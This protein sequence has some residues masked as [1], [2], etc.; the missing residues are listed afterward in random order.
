MEM[1]AAD[2]G[3][4]DNTGR[5]PEWVMWAAIFGIGIPSAWAF[6]LF[7]D[8]LYHCGFN[9]GDGCDAMVTYP[10]TVGAVF[11]AALFGAFMVICIGCVILLTWG[12]GKLCYDCRPWSFV[13]GNDEENVSLTSEV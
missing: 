4:Y 13:S 6:G 1:D 2:G 3:S 5:W 12:V 10:F 8:W 9:W 11:V 7:V